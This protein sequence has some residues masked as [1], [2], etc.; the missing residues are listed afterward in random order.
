MS[1]Y[2]IDR[3]VLTNY[4]DVDATTVNAESVESATDQ[5]EFEYINSRF[6]QDYGYFTQIA[7]LKSAIIMKAIW[8]VGKGYTTDIATKSVLDN[9]IGDGKQTFK[10]ILFSLDVTKRVGRDSF[11]LIVRDPDIPKN[12]IE[13]L[14]N[15]IVLDPSKIK[16]IF[17]RY[18]NIIR[19]EQLSGVGGAKPKVFQPDEILHLSYNKLA[20]SIHGT[21]VPESV[22][23][24]ILADEEN[25]RIM[26]KLTR[27]QAVPFIMFKVKSDNVTTINTFKS[28]I[29]QARAEGEDLIIPDDENILSYE[30]VQ[31]NPSSILMEWRNSLNNSFYQAVGMPLILF[32]SAGQT[33][34]GGKIEYLG[35]ETVFEHEQREIEEQLKAQLGIEINLNPPTSLLDNLAQDENKDSQ[36]ALTFQP[37]DA[38]AGKVSA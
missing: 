15:L 13:S 14:R 35:H 36:N 32:G 27:F 12:R 20:G 26:Q 3:T 31:L 4:S 19:Y 30:V 33:E 8:T 7:K 38:T 23:K 29:K 18:G 34:S 9:I 11:A 37:A 16:I 2:D 22:E 5:K 17:G 1:K 24:I 21:S 25:F 6:T 28:N 10:D